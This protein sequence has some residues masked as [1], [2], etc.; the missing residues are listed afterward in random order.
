VPV[1]AASSFGGV[2]AEGELDG[3]LDRRRAAGA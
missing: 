3:L 1:P 2:V